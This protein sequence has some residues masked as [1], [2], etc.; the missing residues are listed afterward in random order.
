MVS[1]VVAVYNGEKTIKNCIKSVLCTDFSDI[2]V[3]AV[4]DGSTD[5]TLEI[6]ES[7]SDTRLRIIT[8]SNSGQGI[9]RNIGI[10]AAKGDYI[11]FLDADDTVTADMYKEMYRTAIKYNADTVQ[12]A[13]NDITEEKTEIRPKLCDEFVR[14]SD[15]CEYADKYFYTLKHTNEVCNKLFKKS[16]IES[17][18]LEFC[19]TRKIYSEDLKF[20]LDVFC[21]MKSI[22][23][24]GKSMYNYNIN[25][26]GHCK[27][28]PKAR[29]FGIDELYK[30]TLCQMQSKRMPKHI[31]CCIR[32][33]AVITLMQYALPMTDDEDVKKLIKSQRMK[34]YMLSSAIYKHSLKHS[35]LMAALIAMPYS[36]KKTIIKR[37]YNWKG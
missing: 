32:S 21:C 8:I 18:R 3:I 23:F 15:R 6:L 19:D 29:I 16:F 20:N 9:A 25:P 12:C 11:G 10:G 2:E 36:I 35:L 5:G 30:S 34:G 17:N 28:N 7:F 13:I 27:K 31:I 14:V 24:I 37:K 26:N 22:A 4:N 33:M 1:V